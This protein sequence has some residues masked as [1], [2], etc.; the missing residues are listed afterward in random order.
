MKRA[1]TVSNEV[2]KCP[3]VLKINQG[4]SDNRLHMY[5]AFLWKF[6]AIKSQR[7]QLN[8]KCVISR[9]YFIL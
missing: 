1:T 3:W 2:C 7:F 9:L 8:P 6:N 5:S 4:N